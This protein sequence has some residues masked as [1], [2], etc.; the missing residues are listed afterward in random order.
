MQWNLGEYLIR[1]YSD[2][3][4]LSSY[5]VSHITAYH[6]FFAFHSTSYNIFCITVYE[7]HT[8]SPL[9]CHPTRTEHNTATNSQNTFTVINQLLAQRW[10]TGGTRRCHTCLL[11]SYIET[12]KLLTTKTMLQNSLPGQWFQWSSFGASDY[13][14]HRCDGRCRV[15]ISNVTELQLVVFWC[16]RSL[17]CLIY[18][19]GWKFQQPSGILLLTTSFFELQIIS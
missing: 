9:E 14:W 17:P 16:P 18:Q 11:L 2:Y 5:S 3:I 10:C 12:V 19:H 15:E 6:V 1:M 13:F 7:N 4:R 8:E